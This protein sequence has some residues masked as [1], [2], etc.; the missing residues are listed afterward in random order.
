[1]LHLVFYEPY[2]ENPH[3]AQMIVEKAGLYLAH[4]PHINNFFAGSIRPPQRPV[5]EGNDRFVVVLMC[6]FESQKDFAHYMV[7]PDHLRFVDAILKGWWLKNSQLPEDERAAEFVYRIMHGLPGQSIERVR[8]PNVSDE[9]VLAI[10]EWE[11]D[12]E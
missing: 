8:N 12:A 9:Q 11:P 6:L 3:A 1:M 7:D 4:I 2:G 5:G 10:R